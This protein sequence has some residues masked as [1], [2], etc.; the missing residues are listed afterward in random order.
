MK[1]TSKECPAFILFHISNSGSQSFY[2]TWYILTEE[3]KAKK[4]GPMHLPP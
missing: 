2:K 4:S 3:H 1:S